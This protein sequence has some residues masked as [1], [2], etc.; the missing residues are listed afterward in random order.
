MIGYVRLK[1]LWVQAVRQK[2]T[3]A[4]D[5]RGGEGL[6]QVRPGFNRSLGIVSRTD[7]LTGNPGAVM[8]REMLERRG[9]VGWMTG[10]LQDPRSQ[11]DVTP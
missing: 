11:V 8:L 10:R 3:A 7:R 5:A 1:S 6:P 9:R 4:S 2:P